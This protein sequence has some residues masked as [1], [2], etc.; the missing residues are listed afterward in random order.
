MEGQLPKQSLSCSCV[1]L[2]LNSNKSTWLS[3]Q[4][5]KEANTFYQGYTALAKVKDIQITLLSLL[6]YKLGQIKEES[7]NGEI[8]I[9]QP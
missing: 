3:H 6:S 9:G 8:S 5:K 7:R 4:N 1:H 2:D